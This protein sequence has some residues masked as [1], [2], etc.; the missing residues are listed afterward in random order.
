MDIWV[1]TFP[2][3]AHAFRANSILTN[4]AINNKLIPIPRSLSSSC[5]GLAA[6]I[7]EADIVPAVDLLTSHNVAMLYKG[8]KISSKH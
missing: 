1:I 6:Q 7:A 4:N 2:S 8:I 3:V 5:E